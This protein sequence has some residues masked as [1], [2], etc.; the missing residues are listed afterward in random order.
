MVQGPPSPSGVREYFLHFTRSSNNKLINN[1]KKIL[2]F[3][4]K[5]DI[6]G[7]I[8]AIFWEKVAE[9][10]GMAVY[11]FFKKGRHMFF[12]SS[13]FVRRYG[14]LLRTTAI[15][16]FFLLALLLSS[17]TAHPAEISLAWDANSEPDLGG[18]KLYC[19]QASRQY[20]FYIDVGNTLTGTLKDLQD[21]GTYYVAVTAYDASGYESEFSN[22]VEV[23]LLSPKPPE[24]DVNVLPEEPKVMFAINCGGGRYVDPGGNVYQE[25]SLYVGGRTYRTPVAI[26]GTEDDILYQSERFGNFS[27]RIPLPN[28]NYTVT[29]KF[30]EVYYWG[31]GYRVFNVKINGDTV[32][33]H[34]DI[35]IQARKKYKAYDV[36]FPVSIT[37]GMLT[38]EFQT[39]EGNAKVSAILVT[40]N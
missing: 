35:F 1:I 15:L 33:S 3:Y 9:G 7:R 8:F 28:S 29:L 26:E 40:E 19:G 21:G 38:I 36:S 32:L 10:Y 2:D 39:I 4:I 6:I 11:S 34:F 23:N 12:Y 13:I 14:V 18:Y 17:L 25:D 20:N 31:S 5:T 37:D 27:Y 16:P 30:A 24:I 22:E